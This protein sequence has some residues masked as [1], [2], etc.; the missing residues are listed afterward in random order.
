NAMGGTLL[1]SANHTYVT[2]TASVNDVKYD[3]QRRTIYLPVVR[4]AIWEVL[5]AFDFADPSTCNGKRPT[6]TVAP[7]A[8]FMMNS[9]LGQRQTRRMAE[10]LLAPEAVDSIGCESGA[11]RVRVA[12]ERAYG[13]S[14]SDEEVRNALGFISQY[15]SQLAAQDVPADER[16]VRAWQALCRVI[17]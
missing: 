8:L 9:P 5:T 3:N 16:R 13:R 2:S 14:P 11:Q 10:S 1:S 15:E 12:Y 7:Q 17:V 4:S 6:T